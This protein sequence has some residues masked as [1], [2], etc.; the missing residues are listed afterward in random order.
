MSQC[1]K[2]GKKAEERSVFCSDCLAVM[3]QY[4]VKPG[5]V[6]HLPIRQQKQETPA[7]TDFEEPSLLE[8]LMAQRKLIRWLAGIVAG[9]SVLLVLTAVL[10]IHTLDKKQPLPVIGR[11]YTT[12]TSAQK[13]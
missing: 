8:Q 5:T 1:L 7:A 4:P 13:P 11:N 3:E 9:L 2:C 6:I 10:L 12:S